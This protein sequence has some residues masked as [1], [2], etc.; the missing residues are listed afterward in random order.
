[1]PLPIN[2]KQ[3][4]LDLVH[5]DSEAEVLRI[6]ERSGL[7]HPAGWVPLGGIENNLSIVGNQQ[8]S[9]TAAL[10]EK[11]VNGIDSLFLLE[12]RR[13]GIDPESAHA[14]PTMAVAA[15]DFFGIPQGNIARLRPSDRGRL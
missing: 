7:D 1:M 2:L 3:I 4:C 5:A 12:C 13:R 14:P 11:L 9:P 10:V 6:L 8:S 15:N